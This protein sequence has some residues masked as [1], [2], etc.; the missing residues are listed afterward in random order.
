MGI[1][2]HDFVDEGYD[3]SDDHSAF[4]YVCGNY[5]DDCGCDMSHLCSICGVMGYP[6]ECEFAQIMAENAPEEQEAAND[7]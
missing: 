3:P 4:C 7:R 6:C 2:N 1:F 5:G